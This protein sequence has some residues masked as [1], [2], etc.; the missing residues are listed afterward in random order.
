MVLATLCISY[1]TIALVFCDWGNDRIDYRLDHGGLTSHQSSKCES[2]KMFTVWVVRSFVMKLREGFLQSIREI[3]SLTGLYVFNFISTYILFLQNCN[4]GAW[5]KVGIQGLDF[6]SQQPHSVN[7]V[8]ISSV[9]SVVEN[10]TIEAGTELTENHCTFLFSEV[11]E[12]VSLNPQQ[13]FYLHENRVPE[14]GP[15]FV[16]SCSE[17]ISVISRKFVWQLYRQSWQKGNREMA[18]YLSLWEYLLPSPFGVCCSW[19]PGHWHYSC[20]FYFPCS[21]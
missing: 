10:V 16:I 1:W 18:F 20:C 2:G 5:D 3:T 13:P 9:C 7:S 19:Y 4:S 8:C 17:K 14:I 12:F 15:D 6:F 21:G 11:Y